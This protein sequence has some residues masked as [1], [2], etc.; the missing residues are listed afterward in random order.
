VDKEHNAIAGNT[1][2]YIYT[3]LYAI[4]FK[5]K[6]SFNAILSVS[7]TNEMR[8]SHA[9]GKRLRSSSILR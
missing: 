4:I 5:A 6:T 8:R 2:S 3:D 1:H 7:Q 9:N